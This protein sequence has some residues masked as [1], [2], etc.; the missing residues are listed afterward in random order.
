MCVCLSFFFF[1]L[2]IKEAELFLEYVTSNPDTLANIL[3]VHEE[4]FVNATIEVPEV[5][6]IQKKALITF[7]FYT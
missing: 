1:K 6:L 2:P 3:Q 7:L 4:V 5:R